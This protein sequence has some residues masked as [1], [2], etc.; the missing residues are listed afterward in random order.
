MTIAPD[1]Q[2]DMLLWAA[3]QAKEY[4]LSDI[5][6]YCL[7]SIL[8]VSEKGA[9]AGRGIDSLTVLRSVSQNA[10]ASRWLTYRPQVSGEDLPRRA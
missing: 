8:R 3:R 6:K 1:F 10:R 2:M 7:Q 9:G 5:F 4:D